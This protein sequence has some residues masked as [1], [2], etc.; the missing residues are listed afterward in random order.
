MSIEKLPSGKYRATIMHQGK[1]YRKTYD[2]KPT[3]KEIRSDLL[4]QIDSSEEVEI[5]SYTQHSM[6]FRQASEKYVDG[7]RNVLS[8]NTVREYSRTCDRLP[9]WFTEMKLDD[10]TQVSIN[11]CI[12]EISLNRSAKTVRNYHSFISAILGTFRPEM[13][14]YT[15]LPK[16]RLVEPYIPSDEDIKK[17]LDELEGTKF[18]IPFVL[19]CFGLRRSEICGLS[20]S[21]IDIKTGKVKIHEAVAYNENKEWI[22]KGT[23]TVESERTIDIPIWLAEMIHEQGY[24]YKGHPNSITEKMYK[25]EKKLGIEHF[26]VHKLRH[27]FASKMLQITD[28]KTAQKLCGHK[29]DLMI[30]TIYGHS[31]KEEEERAKHE[32][33]TK[34]SDSLF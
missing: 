18:Y 32:A 8:P 5:K 31:I 16:R 7:K 25:V 24:V 10:I 27:Y 20:V 11:K 23:K 12:N 19:G 29:T 30:R 9:E 13:K 2:H 21:D 34:L 17:I 26:S 22:K 1:R 28:I 6:T 3:Q 4:T 33:V 15:T 14:I